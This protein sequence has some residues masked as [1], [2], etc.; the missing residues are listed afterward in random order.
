MNLKTKLILSFGMLALVPL[1]LSSIVGY[2]AAQRSLIGAERNTIEAIADMRANA[3]QQFLNDIDEQM[4][5]VKEYVNVRAGLP[6][7]SRFFRNVS[8]PEY[9]REENILD[10]Q[11][12]EW[13]STSSEMAGHINDIM[14]VNRN[15]IIVYSANAEHGKKEIGMNIS[16]KDSAVFPEGKKGIYISNL[17]RDKTNGADPVFLASAPVLGSGGGFEGVVVLEIST[18]ELYSILQDPYGMGMTGEVVLGEISDSCGENGPPSCLIFLSPTLVDKSGGY[19][20][21]I[22][23]GDPAAVAMQNALKG[24][25]GSGFSVDYAGNKVLAAWRFLPAQK[26]GLVAKINTD[27]I[28]QM[29]NP[30]YSSLLILIIISMAG[31]MIV[32]LLLANEIVAPLEELTAIANKISGGN[33]SAPISGKLKSGGDE[34]SQLSSA[35]EK[36]SGSL[37]NFYAELEKQVDERTKDF[38]KFKLAADNAYEHIIITDIDGTVMYANKAVERI[39]GY[40]VEEIIGKKAGVLWHLPMAKKFYE[41]FWNTIKNK[42]KTFVGEFKN[43]RKNG[44]IY[45]AVVSVAPILDESGEIMFFVGIENDVS[46]ERKATEDNDKLAAIV[47]DTADAVI[48]DDLDGKILSWNKGAERIYGY[49][50][51]EVIGENVSDFLVPKDRR[52]EVDEILSKVKNGERVENYETQ[53]IKKSGKIFDASVT[54]SPIHDQN[55]NIV[56]ASVIARDVTER[57]KMEEQLRENERE[58]TEAQRVGRIGNWSWDIATDAIVWS[59]EYY[60]IFGFDPKKKPPKYEEHLK[61]YTPESAARLDAAVKK[62]TETGKPYELDLEIEKPKEDAAQW[63]TARSETI[64]DSGGKIIGLRGTAQDITERKRAEIEREQFFKFF[65]ISNDIM[66]IA[67][68]LGNF[69]RVN[70]AS[71]RILGYSETELI[72]RP[73]IEFV[74][75]DD[76]QSTSEEMAKQM[77]IGSSLNFVNRYVCK[78]GRVLWMSWR[79]NYD[80]SDGI[81]YATARDITK[82]RAASE[83]NEKLATIVRYTGDAVVSTDLNVNITSWNKGAEDMT[84]YSEKEALSKDIKSLVI[85][86]EKMKEIGYIVSKLKKGEKIENYETQL[87]RKDKTVFD[88]NLTISPIVDESRNVTGISVIARDITKAKEI[89]KAKNDFL[90]LASHQLR[91]P[92]SGMRWLLET[93]RRKIFGDLSPKQKEYIDEVY[94]MNNRMIELVSSMLD[95]LR[96]ESGQTFT[97]KEKIQVS[98]F[99]DDIIEMMGPIAKS[100]KIIMNDK[101]KGRDDIVIFSDF[102]A[103]KNILE[104]FVSNAVSYSPEGKKI[105]FGI[106]EEG[107]KA[108]FYVKDQG[109]G[110]PEEEKTHIFERFFRGYQAKNIKPAGTGLG[111]SLASLIADKMGGKL[112]FESKEGKGSTFYLSLDKGGE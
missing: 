112:S 23:F 27:E 32:V 26:W 13:I 16:E 90:S 61:I 62:N 3:I 51:S 77:K 95:I 50:E 71:L 68:P 53:R 91:T 73:F 6:I 110:I 80:K 31:I 97:K 17:L 86:A 45:T 92:L 67:D 99:S 79:A 15:G 21:Y 56:A 10:G 74:Y 12:G 108:V 66:V 75:P 111:L 9:L 36:M 84:G 48:S 35:F 76:Q 103:I 47:R 1:V 83:T 39:T 69:K 107:R 24:I 55:G 37:K 40:K 70:P 102:Q 88:A 82:E 41:E 49:T 18:K 65:N 7:M 98:K 25:S 101:L 44:E 89:E 105:E 72:S 106:K 81:T 30:L 100:K 5:I 64:R 33:F 11:L 20:K 43:K 28:F 52:K 19:G 59:D 34:V 78:D 63:I 96:L 104:T 22:Q 87:I 94:Q 4:S 109:I 85:P 14:L 57:A 46:R 2:S 8:D 58:L 93:L 29:L 60:R 42:K 54:Y 38:K